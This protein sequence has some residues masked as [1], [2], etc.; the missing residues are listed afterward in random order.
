M[1]GADNVEGAYAATDSYG[2][3]SD[4]NSLAATEEYQ[5]MI[6]RYAEGVEVRDSWVDFEPAI[7]PYN[8]DYV[9]RFV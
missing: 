8:Y 9:A 1:L 3:F 5:N 4:F 2:F 7:I 6:N